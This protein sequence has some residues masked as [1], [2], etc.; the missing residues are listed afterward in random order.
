MEGSERLG[1]ATELC[2]GELPVGG[3]A[4]AGRVP[5]GHDCS[6]HARPCPGTISEGWRRNGRL[7]LLKNAAC[8]IAIL[9]ETISL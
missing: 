1:C 7:P 5:V 6:P 4:A 9:A 3:G 8:G 2:Q